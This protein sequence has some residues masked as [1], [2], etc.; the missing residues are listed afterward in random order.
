MQRPHRAGR[1]LGCALLLALAAPEAP[2]QART[3]DAHPATLELEQAL[4][5]TLAHNRELVASGHRL[6]ERR[7][8][9]EQAGL[10]PNP[11]LGLL[12]EDALGGGDY[13]GFD[14]AD[15]TLSLAWVLEG[16]LRRERV[17]VAEAGSALAEADAEILRIDVAADTA[18]HFLESLTHQARLARADEA[19]ALAERTLDAVGGRVQAGRAPRAELARAR[20]ELAV[21]R[22]ARDDVTHELAIAYRHL[23]A[24]WG[25]TEPGFGR[26]GGDLLALPSI[27]PYE[28]LVAGLERNPQLARYATEERLAKADLRLARA[29][30]WPSLRPSIGVRRHE[31]SDDF[32]LV[33]GVTLPIPLLDRNQGAIGRSR[34]AVARTRAEADAARVRLRT[35]LF[36]L[37]EELEHYLHRAGTLRSEVIPS[38]GEALEGTRRGYERGRYGYAELRSVR[39]DLLR[40]QGDLL[41]ASAG[42]HRLVIAL[43]RLTG[44][45]VAR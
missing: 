15:T 14:S 28:K 40:A 44:E 27:E 17:G 33:A 13:E 32:A 43:E 41:E 10:L 36:A 3:P 6:A 16:R 4:E 38:L 21:S 9:R 18:E 1:A 42:A 29:E 22:L 26:V 34:A 30:R 37:Y 45:R 7:A 35:A 19:I 24:Q 11:Q 12:V 5:R 20:A 2:A 39:A 31:A 25:D 23:A 8:E